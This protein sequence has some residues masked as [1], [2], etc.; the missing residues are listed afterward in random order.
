MSE[1]N[2]ENNYFKYT[3][4]QEGFDRYNQYQTK[5]RETIRDSDKVLINIIKKNFSNFENSKLLDVGCSTGNFLF[6]IKSEFPKVQLEGCDL[7]KSSIESCIHDKDLIGMN[8]FQEDL[9][10]FNYQSKYDIIVANASMVFMNW[11]QYLMGL[12]NI[13]KALKPNGI[14]VSFEWVNPFNVQDLQI[15]ETSLDE[16]EG[17]MLFFRSSK[18]VKETFIKAGFDDVKIL[19]FEISTNL[20]FRGYEED[21]FTYTRQ[22]VDGEKM[23]FRGGLYQP[24]AHNFAKK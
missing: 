9:L 14:F 7:N 11:D 1:F 18:K 6:H 24:W 2:S 20:P 3:Q 15:L 23:S 17:L 21:V 8:F 5:H 12:Q 4:N 19:P 16:P 13:Y 10:K 22:E